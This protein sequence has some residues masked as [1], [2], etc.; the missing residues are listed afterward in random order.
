MK[1][2]NNILVVHRNETF[3]MDKLIQNRDGS[4]YII[5]F[6]LENPYWLLTVASTRYDQKDRY[7]QNWWLDL[8][9]YLRFKSTTPINLKD[10]KISDAPNADSAFN[11]FDD[12]DDLSD[13]VGTYLNGTAVV[14]VSAN[15]AVFY[16]EQADGVKDYRYWSVI[17]DTWQH[18]ECRLIKVFNQTTTRQWVEQTYV[19]SITLVSGVAMKD[20]LQELC[21]AN[22]LSYTD[23][24]TVAELY[25]LLQTNGYEFSKTFNLDSPIAEFEVMKP[26]LVPTELRVMSDIKGGIYG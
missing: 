15:D 17:T 4:P 19:Y 16:L 2:L 24:M 7:I 11:S 3:T 25:E 12:I 21:D 20:Y 5:S 10:F 13:F 8:S 18:Y 26:I 1:T 14:S 6:D 23:N 9:S 22:E